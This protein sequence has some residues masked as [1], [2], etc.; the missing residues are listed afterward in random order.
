[1][2]GLG[3]LPRVGVLVSSRTLAQALNGR[4]REKLPLYS[5]AARRHGLKV[6][7][8]APEGLDF[9][10]RRIRGY[11]FTGRGYQHVTTPLPKVIFRRIIPTQS[12]TRR[13]FRKLSR[14]PGIIVFNPPAQRNKLLVNRLLANSSEIKD[15]IPATVELRS[16]NEA[17]LFI[18]DHGTVYAKPTIGSVGKGVYR[19]R[20]R[21]VGIAGRDW[22]ELRSWRGRTRMLSTRGL[23]RWLRARSGG[24]YILQRGID[25]ARYRGRPFD[26]RATVQRDGQGAWRVTGMVA[27]VARPGSPVTNVGRGGR[28]VHLRKALFAALPPSLQEAGYERLRRLAIDVAN[29]LGRRWQ[30]MGDLGLDLALDQDG[31]P[32]FLEA[33]LREQRPSFGEAGGR[34]AVRRQYAMPMAYAAFLNR[35]AS[36][37]A[38]AEPPA[39]DADG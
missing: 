27:K 10:R 2:R 15:S 6:V 30:R 23:R 34:K 22:Y 7:Y 16:V 20:R 19:V 8:F 28:T 38:P 3:E 24:K 9:G 31:H 12:R 1:M 37:G 17:F 11:V 33:N 13:L 4:S 32:W 29:K 21:P 39:E 35:R 5:R 26:V 14:T 36:T 25:L 18:R